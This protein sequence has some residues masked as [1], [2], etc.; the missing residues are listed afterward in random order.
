MWIGRLAAA[1]AI[2]CLLTNPARAEVSLDAFSAA[3]E[4][5][6]AHNR[7]AL[8]YL[9]TENLALAELELDQLSNAWRAVTDRF[10]AAPPEAFK[11]NALYGSTL[12]DIS[13]RIAS[14]HMLLSAGRPQPVIATL[15]AI[16]TALAAM[17]RASKI[18]VLAD[19][20]LDANALMDGLIRF[21]DDKPDL[22]AAAQAARLAEAGENYARTIRR[23]DAMAPTGVRQDPE[24]RR[25]IDGS[26]AGISL[27]P[28]A[29][30]TRDGNLLHR[31]LI[32]LRSLDNLLAFRYG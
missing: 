24:F 8:G 1:M 2:V 7:V 17:R 28:R 4:Q 27:L 6:S 15:Q 5:A 19:C 11:G 16:R 21:R 10:G 30:E 23:C 25:L 20:V 32:E 3:V 13:V 31:V 12:L 9:R 29:I 18:E 14:A 26:L 22:N